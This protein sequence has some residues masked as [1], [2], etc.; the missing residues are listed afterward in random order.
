MGGNVQL[1]LVVKDHY[2]N[3][4]VTFEDTSIT[5]GVSTSLGP[6]GGGGMYIV[7]HSATL[8]A[9]G[10]GERERANLVVRSSGI[11]CLLASGSEPT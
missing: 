10:I 7:P 4:N 8:L 3:V 1:A 11:F 2:L 9:S 5:D 6:G